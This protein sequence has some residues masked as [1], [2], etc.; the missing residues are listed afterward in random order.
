M[1]LHFREIIIWNLWSPS[2]MADSNCS[3]FFVLCVG[4]S[5]QQV[6][7]LL[8]IF[9]L[10]RLFTNIISRAFQRMYSDPLTPL[11]LGLPRRYAVSKLI[12]FRKMLE[13]VYQ[14]TGLRS[15]ADI[16]RIPSHL[17]DLGGR[18]SE[19]ETRTKCVREHWKLYLQKI[20]RN[21]TMFSWNNSLVP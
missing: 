8:I 5:D 7:F 12:Q 19:L 9:A 21:R 17:P 4:S 18:I 16:L 13:S 3:D 1:F 20:N 14:S 11:E 2:W 6:V 10:V 15:S